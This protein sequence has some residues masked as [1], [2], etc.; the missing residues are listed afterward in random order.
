MQTANHNNNNTPR[1]CFDRLFNRCDGF[2][3]ANLNPT[4][5]EDARAFWPHLSEATENYIAET[6]SLSPLSIRLLRDNAEFR[7][8]LYP[9]LREYLWGQVCGVPMRQPFTHLD[10]LLDAIAQLQWRDRLTTICGFLSKRVLKKEAKRARSDLRRRGPWDAE[11]HARFYQCVRTFRR[12]C[13]AF[14]DCLEQLER[15]PR[16]PFLAGR[17]RPCER[18][19]ALAAL[20]IGRSDSALVPDY[21]DEYSVNESIE[22]ETSDLSDDDDDSDGFQ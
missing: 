21:M 17:D 8:P 16:H 12:R 11:V 15:R 20:G 9:L 18:R 7:G 5:A 1:A 6:P 13:L 14:T 22:A 19:W 2:T 10:E 3:Y 4:T